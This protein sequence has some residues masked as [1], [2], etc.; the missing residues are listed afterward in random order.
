M[1]YTNFKIVSQNLSDNGIK[2]QENGEKESSISFIKDIIKRS[3]EIKDQVVVIK[4]PASIIDN[5]VLLEKLAQNINLLNNCGVKVFI[6]HDSTELVDQTL[7]MFGFSERMIDGVVISDKQSSQIK[8][9]V[10]SGYI[11]K[12]IVSKLCVAGCYAIGVSGKDGDM[13]H[14]KIANIVQK[15]SEDNLVN[16]GFTA[17]PIMINPEILL[18]LGDN[19]MVSVVSPI[20]SDESGATHCV[21]ADLTAASIASGVAADHLIF[22]Y[23]DSINFEIT[24]HRVRDIKTLHSVFS[25]GKKNPR[26]ANLLN[27]S[28]S[29]IAND[30]SCIHFVDS[31]IQD[32]VLLSILGL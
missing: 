23:D 17:E 32:G 18:S 10:L 28:I 27:A 25:S 19:N 21:D 26:V 16:M 4:L 22:I 30:V 13:M 29:A 5:D 7:K 6:V 9:M 12:K 31:K 20:A 24:Q 2:N 3:L 11:N 15:S 1:V 14:A 8:E